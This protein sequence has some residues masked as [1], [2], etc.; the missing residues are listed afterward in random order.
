MANLQQHLIAS[1]AIGI[2][3]SSFMVLN[4]N[5]DYSDFYTYTLA[6]IIGG[7]IPDLDSDDDNAAT[8][9]FSIA[10]IFISSYILIWLLPSLYK[11]DVPYSY[12][13][14]IIIFALGIIFSRFGLYNIFKK[15]TQHRGIWHSIP[16]CIIISSA[17]LLSLYYI[18]G[19][20]KAESIN[21]SWFIFISYLVHLLLDEVVR[22]DFMNNNCNKGFGN[23]MTI[24]SWKHK[25]YYGVSWSVAIILLISL[26]NSMGIYSNII[27]TISS[28][29]SILFNSF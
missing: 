22:K 29:M 17:L 26:P 15:Y 23:A 11:I 10:G 18:L 24:F 4:S 16:M 9:I 14:T 2:V 21:I 7:L 13:S 28:I 1:S 25:L 3:G 27:N 19:Y 6:S 12:V 8:T 5:A 20:S